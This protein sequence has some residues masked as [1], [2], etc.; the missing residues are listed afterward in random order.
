[1]CYNKVLFLPACFLLSF[2]VYAQPIKKI[3]SVFT[4]YVPYTGSSSYADVGIMSLSGTYNYKF[5]SASGIWSEPMQKVSS[6]I[7]AGGTC[8]SRAP[9]A[10]TVKI[11]RV[12]NAMVTGNTSV[13]WMEGDSVVGPGKKINVRAIYEESMEVAFSAG[14]YNWGTDNMFDN[15][16][17]GTNNNNIERFDVIIPSG[18]TIVNKD[19]EG[20]ALYER[21]ANGTHDPVKVAGISG[22][23]GAGDPNAYKA[24]P[25]SVATADWGD[26]PG[27]DVRHVVLRKEPGVHAHLVATGVKTQDRG[28]I[29]IPFASLGFAN[30]DK[31]YGYSLMAPDV[32]PATTAQM[33][34]YTNN[35]VFPLTTKDPAGGIDL[36]GD[37]DI[38][39]VNNSC[40]LSA[41]FSYVKANPVSSG[42]E[43]IWQTLQEKNNSRFEIE[44]S[45]NGID[46]ANIGVVNAVENFVNKADYSFLHRL[47]ANGI[48][49]YRIKQVDNDGKFS[50]T[51]VVKVSVVVNQQ[52]A[53]TVYPNP[54]KTESAEKIQVKMPLPGSYTIQLLD[55]YARVVASANVTTQNG[56]ILFSQD[57]VLPKGY[58]VVHAINVNTGKKQSQGI[59]LQ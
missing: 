35:A 40:V 30:G 21:G 34:N 6:F 41:I 39:R 42:V 16:V 11:R 31:V 37:V 46:Y 5:G 18:Y 26:I 53:M 4:S 44:H 29:F 12:N 19:E 48:N 24:L 13:L 17:A 55:S 3:T 1:M 59:F 52:Q 47:A 8:V 7:I 10:H 22:L 33:V 14:F 54:A 56:L 23:D 58:Y 32:V 57:K 15:A 9:I 28:G 20:F 51:N 25:L 38:F 49:Y 43:V 36:I 27:S 2:A 45:L 50:Y